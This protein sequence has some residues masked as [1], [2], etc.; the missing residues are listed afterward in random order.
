M[1]SWPE[2]RKCWWRSVDNERLTSF[3]N[4]RYKG[5]G[6]MYLRMSQAGTLTLR[7]SANVQEGQTPV[8]TLTQTVLTIFH[9][10]VN[11]AC[12]FVALEKRNACRGM[13]G[14]LSGRAGKYL[15]ALD[16]QP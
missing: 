9:G 2:F 12:P 15:H 11:I 14:S 6:N 1:P 7:G 4:T 8:L 5:T 3:M 16:S 13:A 10:Q